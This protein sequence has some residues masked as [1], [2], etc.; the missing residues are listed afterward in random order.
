MEERLMHRKQRDD[1]PGLSSRNVLLAVAVML[2][3]A[4]PALADV[5][6]K[7]KTVSTGL[8]GFGNGTSERTFVIAGD[9]SR[10][11]DQYT[12]TGRFKTLAGGGKPRQKV[13]IVRLDRELL[14]S[15]DVP[16]KEYDE[17]SFAQ[18]REALAKGMADAQAE[19]DK[20]ENKQAANDV[21]MEYKVDVQR[22]GKKENVNGFDAENVIVTITATPRNKKT[23][24]TAGSYT[25]KMDQWLS[26]QVPGQAETMAFYRKYAEKMGFDPQMQHQVAGMMRQ[27]GD[28]FK[29]AAE[30]MKDLKGYPVRSTV[31][32]ELDAGLTPEQQAQTDKARADE[33]QERAEAK[34]RKEAKE[35]DDAKAEAA[36]SI[37]KG[38][39]GGA[40]GGFLG[41]KLG[42]SA[43]KKAEASASSKG[44]GSGSSGGLTITTDVLSVTTGPAGV[45]FDV[46][47]D[48]KKVERKK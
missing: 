32:L 29:H 48:F 21:E 17:V 45:S 40:L 39:L 10:S 4:A 38:N 14:W 13:E 23:G 41:K 8:A 5:T 37:A 18:F 26:T 25:I 30:K 33:K 9:K 22:T 47:S 12:Y 34:A 6:L 27:Y 44:S 46:P 35:D 19:M 11:D 24:E 3:L 1:A 7:E 42:K 2:A 15:L 43:E 28:A 16:K 31:T 36:G 20:P